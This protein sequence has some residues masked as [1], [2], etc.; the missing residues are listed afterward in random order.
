MLRQPAAARVASFCREVALS[1]VPLIAAGRCCAPSA[2]LLE[3]RSASN[4]RTHRHCEN[5]FAQT[6]FIHRSTG[7]SALY[8]D[9]HRARARAARRRQQRQRRWPTAP[10]ARHRQLSASGE[11]RIGSR[12]TAVGNAAERSCPAIRRH[13]DSAAR[14]PRHLRDD[15]THTRR[16]RRHR[17]TAGGDVVGTA[18]H[19]QA[20]QYRR[21]EATLEVDRRGRSDSP[22]EISAIPAHR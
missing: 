8:R 7:G 2:N 3:R 20:A 18:R 22:R 19:G 17:R 15:I 13:G 6:V 4:P 10:C 9:A 21:V 11:A 14:G 16:R 1:I 5:F 12:T